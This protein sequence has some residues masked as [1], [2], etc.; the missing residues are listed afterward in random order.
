MERKHHGRSSKDDKQEEESE[1]RPASKIE[2]PKGGNACDGQHGE[3]PA[4]GF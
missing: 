2:D 1:R 3:E 4:S